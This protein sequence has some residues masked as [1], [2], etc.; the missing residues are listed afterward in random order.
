VTGLPT[1]GKATTS[2][3]NY[4]ALHFTRNASATDVAYI[5]Q[6]SNNLVQWDAISSFSN[7][8]WSVPGVVIESGTAPNLNVQV[9]DTV[10]MPSAKKRF[11]RLQVTQ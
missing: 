8:S 5:V 4:L 9:Q 11:L 10:P 7:G 6:G 2:G 3:T 1:P